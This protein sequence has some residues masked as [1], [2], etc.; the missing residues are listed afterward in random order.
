[1][2]K[3]LAGWVGVCLLL[4]LLTGLGVL[5]GSHEQIASKTGL[6]P[7]LFNELTIDVGGTELGIFIVAVDERAFS[8]RIAPT[9]RENLSPYV[10][11][12]ALY[13]N[14]TVKQVVD[15][16]PFFPE[17]VVI[18]QE[19]APAFT[20]TRSD[21]VEIT[22]GFLDGRF[23]SNP[24][25]SSYG[26]GSEG[27]LVMGDHIDIE[28]PFWVSY[29]GESVRFE[30]AQ[31]T[32]TLPPSPAA[33]PS[34]PPVEIS[35]PGQIT[36]LAEALTQGEFS[37]AAI[38]DLLALP[39]DLV[40]TLIIAGRGEELRLLLVR[41][42]E[43]IYDSALGDDLLSSLAPLVT[44]GAVMVWALSPTG[45]AFTPWNFYIQQL[46]TNY[47]F[48]SDA[49]FVELTTG[50]LRGRRVEPGAVVAGVIR[51]PGRINTALPF[52]V[53]Y[54]TSGVTFPGGAGE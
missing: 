7:D 23:R 11:R 52:T 46:G 43:G 29:Q 30:L 27:I 24:G 13:V 54:G 2:R 28:R 44:T 36:D 16:F 1:M 10:G 38:A 25:G 37:A 17:Q 50:F 35:P 14:P 31:P 8:S 9:L 40:G 49:S 12:N 22:P 53:Y 41:L 15:A 5:A 4:F 42:E 48:F 32:A 34:H 19:G 51:L 18:E 21:W 26:S 47:V 45:A 39:Q 20:P 6:D 33:T 3:T